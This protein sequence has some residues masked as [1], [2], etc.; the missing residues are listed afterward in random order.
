MAETTGKTT[1]PVLAAGSGATVLISSGVAAAFG[2]ASCCGLP[3]LLATAG[4]S[5]A[6]LTDIALLSAPHRSFLLPVATV[7]LLAGAGLFW[8]QQRQA[9]C[10]PGA[11]C[12]RPA[13]RGATYV[14]LLI[15]AAL[16][17]LG[18]TYA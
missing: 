8:R 5:T 15:G 10:I 9:V 7:C 2:V 14:G 6:W 16:L 4:L 12:A 13:V 11:F 3:F 1:P 18:Y 17:Y